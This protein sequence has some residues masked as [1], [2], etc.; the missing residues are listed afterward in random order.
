MKILDRFES[1][2]V[3]VDKSRFIVANI[4]QEA[5]DEAH[6][7]VVFTNWDKFQNVS[8]SRAL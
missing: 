3:Q 6:V 5:V 4:A 7:R 2:T 1:E 8:I